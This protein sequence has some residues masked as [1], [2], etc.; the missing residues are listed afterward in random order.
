MSTLSA[1][2]ARLR[3][4]YEFDESTAKQLVLTRTSKQSKAD[5][6]NFGP[7]AAI[8]LAICGFQ[9]FFFLH[10]VPPLHGV[11]EAVFGFLFLFA[12]MFALGGA[13]SFL[14]AKYGSKTI[15][16]SSNALEINLQLFGRRSSKRYA[17]C[18]IK[19]RHRAVAKS[20]E[21]LSGQL[22]IVGASMQS[23]AEVYVSRDIEMLQSLGDLL[24]EYTGWSWIE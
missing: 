3:E 14:L 16:V 12:A 20:G 2:K 13:Y 1:A 7:M 6:A 15:R 5:Q 24:A 11:G 4:V 17:D 18:R 23:T 10:V 8:G 19:L 21:R 9:V 22:M